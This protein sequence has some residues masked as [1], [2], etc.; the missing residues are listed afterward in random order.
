MIMAFSLTIPASV[1][2]CLLSM[3]IVAVIF[4]RGAFTALDTARTAEALAFY[5]LGLFAYAAVKVMV[6]VFFALNDTRC[7]VIASFMAVF[8]ILVVIYFTV[9]TPGHCLL[10]FMCHDH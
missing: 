5:S 10:S 4:E 1:G 3:P 7:P 6:P 9:S 2:L 8:T